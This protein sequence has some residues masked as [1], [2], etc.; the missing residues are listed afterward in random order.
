VS[1]S[2]FHTHVVQGMVGRRISGRMDLLLGAGPQFTSISNPCS[3]AD[4]AEGNPHCSVSQS[5]ALVGSIPQTKIGVAA[6]GRLRY[7]W[8]KTDM[9][10][11]YER[12]TTSGSGLFAGAQSDIARLSVNRPLSRVWAMLADVGYARNDRL[13]P[14][15][16]QQLASCF[17]GLPGQP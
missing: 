15:S 12:Y 1:G 5:G 2:A 8:T 17:A 7:R 14:L 6:I 9:A 3:F 10:L 16:N 4:F 11:S 13:Q